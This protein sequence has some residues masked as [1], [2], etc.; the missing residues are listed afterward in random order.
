MHKRKI[1]LD[2][3]VTLDGFIEGPDGEIDWLTG[4]ESTDFADILNDILK[5]IDTV[6]YG[7]I[8]YEKWGNFVPEGD[9]KLLNAY[10]NLHSK[11]KYVFST[12]MPDDGKSIL[13]KSDIRNEVNKILGQPGE[14]IW[15]YGGGSLI[16]TFINEGL[17]DIYRIAVYPVILGAGKP[18]FNNIQKR[19][20]LELKEAKP[21]PSGI[22]LLTYETKNYAATYKDQ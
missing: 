13:I 20:N 4:D 2:L 17:I 8:S 14:N 18:L 22:L 15:L 3:A 21:H 12:S 7:R 16:T 10:A 19:A 9:E 11:K 6:F 5:G 1:I